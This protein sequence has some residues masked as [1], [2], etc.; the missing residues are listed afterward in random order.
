MISFFHYKETI[1]KVDR[2]MSKSNETFATLFVAAD[3]IGE[4]LITSH[5]SLLDAL[6]R[7]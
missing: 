2:V 3:H 4:D 1:N 5:D 7:V 6:N